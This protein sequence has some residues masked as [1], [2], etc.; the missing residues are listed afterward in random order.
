MPSP[1]STNQGF[2]SDVP[3]E[4]CFITVRLSLP[5]QQVGTH[6]VASV[7]TLK[8]VKW[9]ERNLHLFTVYNMPH[10]FTYFVI[11]FETDINLVPFYEW[12]ANNQ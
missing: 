10:I 7:K 9:E 1:E 5:L 12:E 6:D 3:I 8:T 4:S 11:L 2:S